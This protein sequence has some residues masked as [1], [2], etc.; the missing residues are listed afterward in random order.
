MSGLEDGD[1]VAID[2]DSNMIFGERAT[3]EVYSSTRAIVK[4]DL[5]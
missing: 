3:I 5:I 1:I 2:F 4:S